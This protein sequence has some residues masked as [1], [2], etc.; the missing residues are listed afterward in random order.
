MH[1]RLAHLRKWASDFVFPMHVSHTAVLYIDCLSQQPTYAYS[2]NA[3]SAQQ[4]SVAA[5]VI[6]S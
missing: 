2:I 1:Y 5:C 3:L 6:L 4:A